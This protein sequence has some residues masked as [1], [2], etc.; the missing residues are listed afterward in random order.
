MNP[1]RTSATC[2]YELP[3]FFVFDKSGVLC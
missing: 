2:V 3:H 1:A